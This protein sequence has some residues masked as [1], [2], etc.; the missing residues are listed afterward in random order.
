METQVFDAHDPVE[1]D[2]DVEVM[3]REDFDGFVM[4]TGLSITRNPAQVPDIAAKYGLPQM[5]SDIEIV[6][7]G[8]LMHY[9]SN[10]AA[11][12]RKAALYVDKVLTGAKAGDLPIEQA[13]D[14]DFI[15]NLKMAQRLGL[16]IPDHILRQATKVIPP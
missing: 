4:L 15:V 10:Y 3:A 16:V 8:G 9:G 7:A 5:F 11:I 12:Y 13:S 1:V 14:I 6:T 2:A